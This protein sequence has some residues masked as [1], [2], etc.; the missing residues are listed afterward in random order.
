MVI[1]IGACFLFFVIVLF[2][3]VY[4]KNY[5]PHTTDAQDKALL[6]QDKLL[7]YYEKHRNQ[8]EASKILYELWMKNVLNG[9]NEL[10]S[11]LRELNIEELPDASIDQLVLEV[12]AR[13]SAVFLH[14]SDLYL[15]T[16]P[17]VQNYIDAQTIENET[18][19]QLFYDTHI[20][21]LT[22]LHTIPTW[23]QFR[24]AQIL[25]IIKHFLIK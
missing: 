7:T 13:C 2:Y 16:H 17:T 4:L 24:R 15:L 19:L 20:T 1:I 21:Q 14:L 6:E 8:L 23:I 25:L 3:L 11:Q 18:Q 22:N 9:L 10:N 5:A 12:S